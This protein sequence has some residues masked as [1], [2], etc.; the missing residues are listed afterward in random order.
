MSV[1]K[2][3]NLSIKLLAKKLIGKNVL[4][5]HMMGVIIKFYWV[6]MLKGISGGLI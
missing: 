6:L 4:I 1:Q 5:N 2:V 3:N